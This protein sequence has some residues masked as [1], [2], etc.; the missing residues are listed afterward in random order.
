[1]ADHER[2]RIATVVHDHRGNA[3]VEWQDAPTDY[4]RPVL[5]IADELTLAPQ[6]EGSY[7]PYARRATRQAPRTGNTTRTD[8]RKLSEWIK[9]MRELEERKRRGGPGAGGDEGGGDPMI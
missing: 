5:E 4:Q 3:S 7:D 2:R 1:M 6:S 9:M 8:L